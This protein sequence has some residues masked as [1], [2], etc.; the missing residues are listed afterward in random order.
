MIRQTIVRVVW[1]GVLASP[2]VAAAQGV[3]AGG[4]GNAPAGTGVVVG[5]VS[6]RDLQQ[7]VSDAV[8]TVVDGTVRARTTADGHF[9]LIGVPA[10]PIQVRAVRLGYQTGAVSVTVVGGSTVTANLSLA[11]VAQTL[12][13][14][15]TNATG[16]TVVRRET[17][18]NIAVV[19]ADSIPQ[20]AIT[21]FSDMLTGR[22]AGVVVE[23]S[24]GE[25]G[26]GSTVR[27]RGSNSLYLTNE[28]I[29]I[30]DGVRLDNN[31]ATFNI[32]IGGQSPSR[33]D[34]IPD[35]DIESIE[36]LKGPTAAALYGTAAANGI[37]QITTKHG[38]TGPTHWDAYA[39][40]GNVQNATHFPPNYGTLTTSPGFG[41][42]IPGYN[43]SVACTLDEQALY[44]DNA[45]SEGCAPDSS[46]YT[47]GL[48]TYNP[49]MDHS[50]FRIGQ[51]ADVGVD[52]H[53]GI[54][55][56]TFYISG[57]KSS[58]TGIYRNNSINKATVRA[59]AN[60]QLT[61]KLG[62]AVSAGYLTQNLELPQND[63][64]YYGPL[65]DG[66]LG[67]PVSQTTDPYG[68]PSFGYNPIPPSQT[69]KWTDRQE[70]DHYTVGATVNWHPLS[71]LSL[72]GVTGLDQDFQTDL[73]VEPANEVFALAS[74]PLGHN[75]LFNQETQTLSENVAATAT[76]HPFDRV[77]SKT[78]A[79]F[80]YYSSHQPLLNGNGIG[81]VA[82][83]TSLAGAPL[84]P[85]LL[86][87]TV[88]VKQIGILGSEQLEW[89]ERRYLTV[90]LRA[91]KNSTFGTAVGWTL[92][93]AANVSWVLSDEDF[94]PRNTTVSSLRFHAAY[95]ASGLNPQ[96]LDAST[97]FRP[98]ATKYQGTETPTISI[99]G[100]GST[101]LKPERT[102][103]V[104][105]GLEW[106]F[107][108]D[109]VTFDA[110]TY[111]KRTDDAL[112]QIPIGGSAGSAV[113][114]LE[115]LGAVSNFGIELGL[116]A[117]ILDTRALAFDVSA[118][119]AGNK[120]RVISLGGLPPVILGSGNQ[121][122]RAGYPAGGFWSIPPD[123]FPT[124]GKN[125]INGLENV[126]WDPTKPRQFL[127]PALP[128][129]EASL[130]PSFLIM[131]TVRVNALFD[132]R[133]GVK[134]FDASE[135]FR[136]TF[137]TCRGNNDPTASAQD[138]ACAAYA[139]LTG[140]AFD[141][142]WIEDADFIKLREISAE[143]ILPDA[144]AHTVHATHL[145]VTVAARNLFTLWT[146]F[147][148]LDPETDSFGQDNYNRFQFAVQPLT[149]YFTLRVNA[150]F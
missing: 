116:N 2:A 52:G 34:E 66:Y 28:P 22:A 68:N 32:G 5:Q 20:A 145:S 138:K 109:R 13:A 136:C 69:Y 105:G 104:E 3:P 91:D 110:T 42:V 4:S 74:D 35:Q 130:S 103:E 96:S 62:V 141:Y 44:N 137:G 59:N 124:L 92:Y 134:Q 87:S 65:S 118:T 98:G 8:V 86:D 149:R 76:W 30:V 106:G 61:D 71:W 21:D 17:G 148:G 72:T 139:L 53:G 70:L 25:T 140:G 121:E 143:F 119:F 40:G 146:P 114:E 55:G 36:I 107:L 23:H 135:Q 78:T 75:F 88:D 97:Y 33:L 120:N 37:V 38:S 39:E 19:Q 81:Q 29:Y 63:N 125:G 60:F 126:Y 16:E 15:V 144:W 73:E 45:G 82:G 12:N 94:W 132:Y 111:F 123:S 56:M 11:R 77:T 122:F 99:G 127:G 46:V 85:S 95:G 54:A 150:S 89:A 9:R 26:T 84:N 131:R 18:A 7:P 102:N 142:C 129:R 112:V 14:V 128:V 93:P 108:K 6:D 27:I 80:Q 58:E 90:S 147:K 83:T 117:S 113:S 101:N 48:V 47:G 67:Y 49:I 24:S 50:P 43:E 64:G 31:P 133:G 10:G 100:I 51:R 57:T 79:G 1:C 115:N 41:A